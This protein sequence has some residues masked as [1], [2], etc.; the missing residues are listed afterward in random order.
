M[1]SP[2]VKAAQQEAQEDELNRRQ[3][4]EQVVRQFRQDSAGTGLS[5]IDAIAE[6]LRERDERAVRI[7]QETDLTDWV[8]DGG[9]LRDVFA[10][11]ILAE[12][13]PMT[14]QDQCGHQWGGM[15]CERERNHTGRHMASRLTTVNVEDG[16]TYYDHDA[17]APTPEQEAGRRG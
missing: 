13:A 7:I 10:A 16:V 5:I 4:A 12:D 3:I 9:R 2:S 17:D 11:A 6:A 1:D 15:I 14:K 8:R